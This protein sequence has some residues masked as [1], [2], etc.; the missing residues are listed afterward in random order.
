[1]SKGAGGQGN[2]GKRKS[3]KNRP[4]RTRRAAEHRCVAGSGAGCV[5]G[6]GGGRSPVREIAEKAG[7]GVGTVYRHFPQRSDLIVA[8][9]RRQVDAC[10]DAAPVLA[11]KHKPGEA[12]ARWDAAL[13]RLHRNQTR[14]G[15]GPVLGKPGLRHL[16]RVLRRNDSSPLFEHCSTQRQRRARCV[17]MLSHTTCCAP[18][19]ASVCRPTA[20]APRLRGDHDCSARQRVTLR[21]WPIDEQAFLVRTIGSARGGRAVRARASH[22]AGRFG[23][24]AQ[25]ITP[26]SSQSAC[27]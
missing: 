21:C 26:V 12:L 6:F 18:S 1:M 24:A 3:S 20:A 10:A 8:V 13:R 23:S 14:P 7:V 2:Y 16:A 22:P 17:P 4:V 25:T 19:A 15:D 27:L 9:F 5:R 11:A